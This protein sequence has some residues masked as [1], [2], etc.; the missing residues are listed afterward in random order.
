MRHRGRHL[1]QRLQLMRQRRVV[2]MP[3]LQLLFLLLVY[4]R[5]LQMGR[6]GQEGRIATGA[7]NG[8]RVLLI[9]RRLL[10][11]LL[12]L[13]HGKQLSR[14]DALCLRCCSLRRQKR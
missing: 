2:V 4:L 10:L 8:V 7:A 3:R 5:L 11:L 6:R 12:L 13:L 1:L 9:I 14:T